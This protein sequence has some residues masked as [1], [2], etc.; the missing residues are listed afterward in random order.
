MCRRIAREALF[1]H[2]RTL[3]R[4]EGWYIGDAH[5]R[6]RRRNEPSDG[7]PTATARGCNSDAAPAAGRDS[8]ENILIHP[9][10]LRA[11]LFYSLSNPFPSV[12]VDWDLRC[13]MSGNVSRIYPSLRPI[14]TKCMR[15][16]LSCDPATADAPA[17]SAGKE[18][19]VGV[20]SDSGV[21]T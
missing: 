19:R 11:P 2:I 14:S 17:L 5:V 16:D 12:R 4:D 7:R 20:P 21:R 18:S 15:F 10:A 1:V 6:G 13:Q 8:S 3:Q 9:F